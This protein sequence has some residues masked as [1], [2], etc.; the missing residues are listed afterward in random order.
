MSMLA[1]APANSACTALYRN[2]PSGRFAGF[3]YFAQN[4][5]CAVALLVLQKTSLRVASLVFV[6][7]TRQILARLGIKYLKFEL[8]FEINSSP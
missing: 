5:S 4:L 3:A 6:M 1:V 8:K 7:Q 2:L